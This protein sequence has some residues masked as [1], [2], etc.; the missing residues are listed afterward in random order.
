MRRISPLYLLLL[1]VPVAGVLLLWQPAPV[2]SQSL[3]PAVDG[4]QFRIIVGLK[5]TDAKLWNGKVTVTGGEI[6]ALEGWRAVPADRAFSTGEFTFNTK[7]GLLEN[8]LRPGSEYGQTGVAGNGQNF[9][10]LI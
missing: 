7:V 6:L 10:H 9:Q 8:Q 4:Q 3:P 5:D 2:H 1:A